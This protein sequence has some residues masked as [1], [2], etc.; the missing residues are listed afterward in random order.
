MCVGYE[1]DNFITIESSIDRATLGL[2][3]PLWF[4]KIKTDLHRPFGSLFVRRQPR[5]NRI[6]YP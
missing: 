2:L 1:V 3:Q 6:P 4:T 5:V